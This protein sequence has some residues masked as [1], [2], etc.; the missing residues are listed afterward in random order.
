VLPVLVALGTWGLAHR[1]GPRRLR[2]RAEV[3]RDRGPT[4]V[5]AL[6]EEIR[7]VHLGVP[8]PEPAVPRPS[9]RLRAAYDDAMR[10]GA[11]R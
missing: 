5:A 8:R 3:L 1:D 2:A 7:E 11:E 9:E 4:L 10:A 6:M